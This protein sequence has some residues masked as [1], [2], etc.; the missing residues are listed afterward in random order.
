MDN[1]IIRHIC[2]PLQENCYIIYNKEN[3]CVIIDPGYEFEKISK[4]IDSKNLEP[5]YILLTHGHIDHIGAVSELKER[6]SI[7]VYIH[8]R[9]KYM[10]ENLNVE[11]AHLYGMNVKSTKVDHTV[12][13]N[14]KIAFGDKFI[15]VIETPGHTGGGICYKFGNLLFSGDTLFQGSIGRYDF[16][17]S[18]GLELMES[19]KKLKKLPPNTIVLPGHGPETTI[20][21]ELKSNPYLMR[22]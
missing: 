14:D 1:K 3:K 2:G 15:E 5:L 9:D 4:N 10:L 22:I 17:E 12:K 19:L 21:N 16:P 6:Y 18:S 11:R 8:E 7:N 20:E 13:D